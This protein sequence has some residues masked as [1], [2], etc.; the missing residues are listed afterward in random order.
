MVDL[1]LRKLSMPITNP[2][3]KSKVW[4][5]GKTHDGIA[6]GGLRVA[7]E[8]A[9]IV[10]NLASDTTNISLS[11]LGLSLGGLYARY[12]IRELYRRWSDKKK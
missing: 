7:N 12:T 10:E 9:N 2:R 8:I 5:Y 3:A 1:G 6:N 11:I 4:V